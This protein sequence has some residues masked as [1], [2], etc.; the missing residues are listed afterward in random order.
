MIFNTKIYIYCSLDTSWYVRWHNMYVLNFIMLEWGERLVWV[1]FIEWTHLCTNAFHMRWKVRSS[2]QAW[3]EQHGAMER[4]WQWSW[5]CKGSTSQ[6]L[7]IIQIWKGCTTKLQGKGICIRLC[8]HRP[9]MIREVEWLDIV[10]LS[11]EAN[12]LLIQLS[13]ATRGDLTLYCIE[14]EWHGEK[15]SKKTFEKH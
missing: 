15:K 7:K 9:R 2:P 10:V 8:L 14:I 1:L 6:G 13:S 11:R 12:S 3:V 4:R 5:K